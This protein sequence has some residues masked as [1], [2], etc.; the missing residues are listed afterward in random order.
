MW[1]AYGIIFPNDESL[2]R[3]MFSLSSL[4]VTLAL[5]TPTAPQAAE[6]T[7]VTGHRGVALDAVD[8][9]SLSADT[10]GVAE[11]RP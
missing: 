3:P 2:A 10:E 11:E 5:L 6:L 4:L 7:T 1:V 8:P 9:R